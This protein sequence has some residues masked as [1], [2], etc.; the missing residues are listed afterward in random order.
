MADTLDD[1]Q[2]LAEQLTNEKPGYVLE[3]QGCKGT[4]QKGAS[5]AVRQ[6]EAPA[7]QKKKKDLQSHLMLD[8][9]NNR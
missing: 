9:Q 1:V 7:E 6:E 5:L 8:K 3:R 4:V 2:G